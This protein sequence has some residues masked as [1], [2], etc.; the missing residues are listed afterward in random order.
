[1]GELP[2]FLNPSEMLKLL[3]PYILL[4]STICAHGQM[5]QREINPFNFSFAN[6]IEAHDGSIYLGLSKTFNFE[7]GPELAFIYRLDASTL[8]TKDSIL[9]NGL[10]AGGKSNLR[11]ILRDMKPID[12]LLV[13]A[14]NYVDTGSNSNCILFHSGLIFFDSDLNIVKEIL[15]EDNNYPLYLTTFN[16]NEDWIVLAGATLIC[17]SSAFLNPAIGIINRKT[18]S[19]SWVDLSLQI[20]NPNIPFEAFQPAV[21]GHS[22]YANMWPHKAPDFKSNLILDTNLT[23]QHEGSILEPNSGRL[24][25]TLNSHGG[26]IET[27]TGIVQMGIAR[28]YLDSFLM[29]QTINGYWNL[30]YTYLDSMANVS[31]FDTLPLSGYDIQTSEGVYGNVSFNFD[32]IDY[33]TLDSVLIILNQKIVGYLNYTSKDT[34]SFFIYNLNL[35]TKTVN[36]SKKITR[37]LINSYQSI[38]CLPNNQYAISFNEYNWVDNPSPNL[39]T[40]VWIL[41]A[42]GSIISQR[43]FH[44]KTNAFEIYPNPTSD[45]LKVNLEEALNSPLRYS[46]VNTKGEIVKQGQI[47]NEADLI[48]T[49]SIPTG[50]YYLSITNKGTMRFLKE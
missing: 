37:N 24:G 31:S 33:S 6:C 17:D 25:N 3:S 26:F 15:F 32:G 50:V 12:S 48:D 43:E 16:F 39:Q 34:V 1:M 23:V 42:N 35:N 14:V 7:A 36:W 29:P 20:S 19:K 44:S 11:V 47:D 46:I 13:A 18:N 8:I 2:S 5:V 21:F 45:Y 40:Q 28:S 27:S 49:R 38:T 41:D 4:F 22:V 30:A 10:I 9:L